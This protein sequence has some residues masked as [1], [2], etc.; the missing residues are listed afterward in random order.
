MIS[1]I[2]LALRSGLGAIGDV[3]GRLHADP[4]DMMPG[5]MRELREERP[6]GPA[7]AL[8]ERVQGIDVSEKLRQ[9]GK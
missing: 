7:V 3:T 6:L 1:V 9:P 4:A 8:P 5:V 2:R